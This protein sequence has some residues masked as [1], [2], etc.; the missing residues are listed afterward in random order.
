MVH[1]ILL[2][3]SRLLLYLDAIRDCTL[4]LL[5]SMRSGFKAGVARNAGAAA[6]LGIV[7]VPGTG[8]AKFAGEPATLFIL[9]YV[10]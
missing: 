4:K 5:Y 3:I 6:S 1:A 9:H 10:R 8:L 2:I 7:G